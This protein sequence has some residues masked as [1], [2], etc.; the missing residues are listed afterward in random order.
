MV[1]RDYI[2]GF[3]EN[4]TVGEQDLEYAE[5]IG[6][7]VC[8]TLF[9]KRSNHLV[10][11]SSGNTQ[12]QIEYILTGKSQGNLVTDVKVIAGEE[13]VTQ[14]KLL[15]FVT[16]IRFPTVAKM[17]FAPKLCE[18]KCIG[19]SYK[20]I[21]WFHSYLKNRAFFLSLDKVFLEARTINCGVSQ[22]SML[23]LLL[24]LLY[25]NDIPQVP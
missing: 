8:N 10:T 13:Y 21:K 11:Y 19:F 4:N 5:S 25:I 14:H 16:K 3:G 9:Q 2:G 20:T 12:T 18:I 1:T 22:G 15:V 6:L 24:F 23:G 17:I 7:A